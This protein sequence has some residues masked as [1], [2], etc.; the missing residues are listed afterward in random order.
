MEDNRKRRESRRT[1]FNEVA[2]LYDRARPSYPD[3]LFADLAEFARTGPGCR[4]LE[5]GCGTGQIT[6]PLASQDCAI[7]ALDIGERMAAI[8]RQKIAPYPEAQVIVADFDEW[9][10]PPEPFDLVVSASAFHWIDPAIRTQKCARSLRSGG[11]LAI[12]STEHIR[13]GSNEFFAEVQECY[14]RW[15]PETPIENQ[16]PTPDQIPM[17]DR[18]MERSGLFEKPIFRRYETERTYT[19]AAYLDVLLT[20]SGHLALPEEKRRGLLDCIGSLID[21]RYGGQIVKRY[22]KELRLAYRLGNC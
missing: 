14:K 4:V 8:A 3:E 11:A 21:R 10:L 16:L 12:I 1:T 19:T 13:G 6:L 18:E 15:D 7:V 2:E 22:M 9:P 17:E 20:Y 5:I